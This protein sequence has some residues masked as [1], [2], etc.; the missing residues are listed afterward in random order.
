M[1]N[2]IAIGGG[3]TVLLAVDF[4]KKIPGCLGYCWER[5]NLVT[6]EKTT[7]TSLVPFIGAKNLDNTE[8]PTDIWPAQK[9]FWFD[10]N[11]P[12]E[13]RIQYTVTPIVGTPQM[14]LRRN[15]L[16]VKTNIMVLTEELTMSVSFCTNYGMLSQ[17]DVSRLIIKPDG[18]FDFD[19]LMSEI[20]TPGAPLRRLLSG[21]MSAF[22]QFLIKK[23]AA[24]GGRVHLALY[25][26]D[27][28]ELL[29]CILDNRKYVSIILSNTGPDDDTNKAARA[30][31]HAAGVDITDRFLS[32]D[33]IGH[34]K[35]VVYVDASGVAQF[36]QGGSVNWT[37]TG[38]CTQTNGAVRVKSKDLAAQALEYWH[39]LKDDSSAKPP[40]SAVFRAANAKERPVILLDDGSQVK[41]WFSP[42]MQ[43]RQKPKTNPP[44]PPD[45]AEVIGYVNGAE[46]AVFGLFFNPGHPSVLDA[47]LNAA[48]KNP[49]LVA[50][51]AVSTTQALTTEQLV[52]L[53]RAGENPV[54]IPASGIHEAFANY[55]AEAE[56]AP[57]THARIH[58][59]DLVVDPLHV[60]LSKVKVVKTCHNMGYTASYKNDEKFAN[61]H[62][63][64]RSGSRDDGK[65]LLHYQRVPLQLGLQSEGR[66]PDDSGISRSHR[67][68]AG[69]ILRGGKHGAARNRLPDASL[70]VFERAY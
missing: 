36:F 58:N 24:E 6:G 17:Q 27:D 3:T 46:E 10:R 52:L 28:P 13:T 63:E 70:H 64:P 37:F 14:P 43:Q 39:Q 69:Q 23:A 29:Q 53:H 19:K 65:H 35:F 67:R 54:V 18:T 32:S 38:L 9:P 7:L 49:N 16:A 66:R 31:L 20:K 45:M 51:A 21:N 48:A 44:M 60:D 25:E 26:L 4:D 12:V 40:Q 50:R 56:Q 33:E 30:A 68:L 42:N 11:A 2:A 5:Q 34:N 61:F 57:D 22:L 41:F 62:R 47:I 8:K 59:K 1:N 15:D 55:L